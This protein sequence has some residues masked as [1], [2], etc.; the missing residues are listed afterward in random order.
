[1]K[2]EQYAKIRIICELYNLPREKIDPHKMKNYI[3]T[4][5][6]CLYEEGKGL[7]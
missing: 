3:N 4:P 7:K 2:C 5:D 1:M 6:I